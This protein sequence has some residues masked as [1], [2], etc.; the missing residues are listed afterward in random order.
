MHQIAFWSPKGGA[1]KTTLALNFA[2][3]A[4]A[5]G[6]KVIVYDLDPQQSSVDVFRDKNLPFT[7]LSGKPEINPRADL[8]V[9]DYPP[10][11]DIQVEGDVI[12]IPLRPSVLD[13]RAVT[14]SIRQIKQKKI[15]KCI[16]AVDV[17]RQ[18]ERLMALR[19]YSEGAVLIKDRSIYP[20]S[21][22]VGHSVFGIDW[23]G[24]HDAQQEVNRLYLK[25]MALL[26]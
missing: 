10:R 11:A 26:D 17:R 1:G 7:V 3:A 14:K 25:V 18:D 20:R 2:A 9:Y 6:K 13:L 15:I 19:F 4:C 21:I 5:A 12:V 24:T 8:I 16:N 23:Y 22:A